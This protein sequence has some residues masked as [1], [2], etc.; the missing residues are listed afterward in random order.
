M[1]KRLFTILQYIFFFALGIFLAWWSIRDLGK[2]DRSEIK[3]ALR[4]A[5]YLLIIPVILVLLVSHYL[6]GIR[7]GLLIE[8]L[9]HKPAK[10]NTF[11]SVM[12]GYLTNLAFPRLGEVM[13]C[14]VLARYE[15]NPVD[16]LIG[17]VILERLIDAITL[18]FVFGITLAIQPGIYSQL[19]DTFFKSGSA[20]EKNNTGRIILIVI[21][22]LVFLGVIAWMIIKKKNLKDLVALFKRIVR[23][24]WQGVSAIRHLKKRMSFIILSILIWCLYLLSGYIGFFALEETSGYGIKEAFSILSAG[25]VGMIVTPGGIGAYAVLIEKTMQLYGLQKG[26]ALAFGWLLWIVQT[27]SILIAGVF[28]FAYLPYFNNKRNNEKS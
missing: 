8:P 24:V 22:G 20:G 14:T 21:V 27:G 11:L 16:K 25:S 19:I 13:R 12:I 15:K 4:H 2:D 10:T 23:S 17:T 3:E 18:L 9:G 7:W 28:S 6:R 26:F 1:N 5:R